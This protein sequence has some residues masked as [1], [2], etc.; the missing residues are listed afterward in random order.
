MLGIFGIV[1]GALICVAGALGIASY[2]D[3]QNYY[4]NGCH[5]GFS[6]LACCV[7][8]LGILFFFSRSDV[9]LFY[10]WFDMMLLI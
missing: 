1:E 8:V 2:K 9:S 7:S 3:P 5:M 10:V 4:K 6:I